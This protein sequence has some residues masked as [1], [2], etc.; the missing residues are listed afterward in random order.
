ME[1]GNLGRKPSP[2]VIKA[3]ESQEP[4]P[5]AG[6]DGVF[7][8]L[9]RNDLEAGVRGGGRATE[10]A[11]QIPCGGNVRPE[12]VSVALQEAYGGGYAEA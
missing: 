10:R 9:L 2:A 6:A 8:R 12:G 3:R 4:N 11:W 7:I 1:R 5:I